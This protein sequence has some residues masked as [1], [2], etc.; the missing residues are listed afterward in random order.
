MSTHQNPQFLNIA[1][2]QHVLHLYQQDDTTALRE[3][4]IGREL[5]A[6]LGQLRAVDIPR[7]ANNSARV[8]DIH[9]DTRALS[10]LLNRA[11]EESVT[12]D[13]A[14]Q[15]VAADAPLPMMENLFDWSR[16]RYLNQRAIHGLTEPISRGR[17]ALPDPDESDQYA[18][19]WT[20]QF[21]QRT[22]IQPEEYLQFHR[23]TDIPLRLLWP[24]LASWR[25][26]GA[27]RPRLNV[28]DR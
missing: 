15:L 12:D 6:K 8:L 28:V 3:L 19:A 23:E 25:A 4:G 10:L 5:L 27:G 14:R 1:A 9:I 20:Q 2:L 18:A 22:D 11:L 16:A 7:L 26:A 13:I 17:P 21:G 24:W